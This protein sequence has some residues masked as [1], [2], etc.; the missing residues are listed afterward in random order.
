MRV[1]RDVEELNAALKELRRGG[2]RIG[3]VPT[4]GALHEGHLSLVRTARERSDDAVVSIFVNPTQ[5]G[6]KE[7]FRVY[8][9]TPEQDCAMLERE[10]VALVF[11]PTAQVMYPLP[12]QVSV[13]PGPVADSFE[14]KTRPGHFRGVL[15]VVMKFL[16]LVQPDAA[17]FG[18]K[19]G[20]QLYLVKRMVRDLNLPVEIVEGTTMREAD[21]LAMSSRNRFLKAAERERA[22]VL[23]RALMEGKRLFEAGVRGLD[24]VRAAMRET[25]RPVSEFELDYATAVGDDDFVESDP[26][27]DEVRLII[28][29]RLGSVRL[30]DNVPVR[31]GSF[32]GTSHEKTTLTRQVE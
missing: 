9:R 22:T 25:V 7:D 16:N 24:D 26:L 20:Q 13:D 12:G 18:Q 4:M 3:F 31:K 17:V 1:A 8:P 5:F 21:G 23:Y 28:A 15:T 6:P 19:D 2:R 11:M 29:G 30:I 32:C 10:G 14:G 27:R